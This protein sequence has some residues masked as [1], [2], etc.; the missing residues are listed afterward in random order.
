MLVLL[1]HV[2]ILDRRRVGKNICK[3]KQEGG[4]KIGRPRLRLL[5]VG[6]ND[7]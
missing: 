5:E 4:R 2:V 7:L 1:L 3:N 6:E